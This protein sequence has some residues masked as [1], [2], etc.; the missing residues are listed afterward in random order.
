MAR[1]K[2]TTEVDKPLVLVHVVWHDA[3]A[4]GETWT[5]A[6]ELDPE[7]CVVRSVG[8]ILPDAKHGHLTLA[9][10]LESDYRDGILAIPLGMVK[11]VSR[12]VEEMVP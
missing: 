8:W 5:T 12:L 11:Q 1:R 7:P 6:E 2:D 10:S 4:L 3:H 9:Q